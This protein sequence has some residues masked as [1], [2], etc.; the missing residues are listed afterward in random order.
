MASFSNK[1]KSF[2]GSSP[3][4]KI[5]QCHLFVPESPTS[6]RTYVLLYGE[7]SNPLAKLLKNQFLN[8]SQVVV[9]QDANIL[10]KIYPNKPQKIKLNNEVG[11]DWVKRNFNNW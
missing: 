7:G 5:T 11:M 2:H 6:T 4:G 10:N 1:S 8:L 9:E 3:F